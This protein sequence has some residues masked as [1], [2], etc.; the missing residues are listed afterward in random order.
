MALAAVG[1][2]QAELSRRTGLSTK[3]VNQICRENAGISAQ[4]AVL[5]EETLG[6][7]AEHWMRLQVAYDLTTAREARMDE[8]EAQ[9]VRREA[10][11]DRVAESWLNP[12]AIASTRLDHDP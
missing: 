11:I 9:R 6:V 4:S 3:H 2:R 12:E 5:L 1:M 7:P 8:L 10:W